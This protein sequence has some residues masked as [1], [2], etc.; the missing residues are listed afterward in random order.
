M[1]LKH[2]AKKRGFTL[3]EIL[4][5]IT[6]LVILIIPLSSMILS[7]MK[8]NRQSEKLQE[9]AAEGQS[10]IEEF[11]ALDNLKLTPDG[12]LYKYRMLDGTEFEFTKD[13]TKPVIKY[14]SKPK[15]VG[16]PMYVMKINKQTKDLYKKQTNLENS[17][18]S[19]YYATI[20]FKKDNII[21]KDCNDS[22]VSSF[23]SYTGSLYTGKRLDI[24]LD[25]SSTDNA[26]T[27]MI[28]SDFTGDESKDEDTSSVWFNSADKPLAEPSESNA[29]RKIKI[30]VDSDFETNNSDLTKYEGNLPV[31]IH[32]YGNLNLSDDDKKK[33]DVVKNITAD[34]YSDKTTEKTILPS[35]LYQVIPKSIDGH[36]TKN[37]KTEVK[38][39][40]NK[41]SVNKEVLGDLCTMRIYVYDKNT[42]DDD[43]KNGIKPLFKGSITSNVN[44]ING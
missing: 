10:Y 15:E 42:S 19:N 39:A 41:T 23:S 24:W 5:S 1:N 3:I 27:N 8:R 32:C 12:T 11:G 37:Y 28:L 21:V 33:D 2:K 17:K 18:A 44:I 43:I 26:I 13:E 14:T 40:Q 38:I 16:K 35:C 31:K 9:A 36:G 20:E 30:V 6:I 7:S 4:I 34:I 29:K 25:V 22:E